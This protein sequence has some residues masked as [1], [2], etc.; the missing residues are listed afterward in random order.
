MA[1]NDT[2]R[3]DFIDAWLNFAQQ[4]A[5]WMYDRPGQVVIAGRAL[6]PIEESTALLSR[7]QAARELNVSVATLQRMVNRGDLT[8]IKPTGPN[9]RT[10][11]FEPEDIARL[12]RKRK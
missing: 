1:Q 12:K 8:P 6:P 4:M 9:G 11:G 2:S 7:K 10:R 5:G 3:Q